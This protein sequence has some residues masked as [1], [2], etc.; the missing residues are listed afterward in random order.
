MALWRFRASA[1]GLCLTAFGPRAVIEECG[2]DVRVC[3]G[4]APAAPLPADEGTAGGPAEPQ[5][6]KARTALV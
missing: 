4:G 2:F 6:I 5:K 3:G 1:C